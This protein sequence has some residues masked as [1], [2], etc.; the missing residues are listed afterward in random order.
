VLFLFFFLSFSLSCS[1][2]SLS[3]SRS[4]AA[5]AKT[6]SQ[7]ERHHYLKDTAFASR[8]SLEEIRKRDKLKQELTSK[9]GITLLIVPCWWDNQIERYLLLLC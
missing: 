4:F 3:L 2:F 6:L 8:K 7:K 5:Y 1:L 9:S